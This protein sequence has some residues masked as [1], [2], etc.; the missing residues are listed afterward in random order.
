ME[1]AERKSEDKRLVALAV[2]A[3]LSIVGLPPLHPAIATHSL[4]RTPAT[5]EELQQSN[6]TAERSR[7]KVLPW[8]WFAILLQ[9]IDAKR[10]YQSPKGGEAEG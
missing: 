3:S 9:M 10:A 7:R 6:T 8:G 1:T 5:E 2:K 4:V